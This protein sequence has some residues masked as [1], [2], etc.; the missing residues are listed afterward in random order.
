VQIAVDA[1]DRLDVVVNAARSADPAVEDSSVES[2][3]VP[4]ETNLFGFAYLIDATLPILRQQRSGHIIGISP[5]GSP[6]LSLGFSGY[7]IS[8][9]A[10]EDFTLD[11]AQKV[12]PFGIK[13]TIVETGCTRN[14]P[15]ESSVQAVSGRYRWGVVGTEQR[16]QA[17]E[18][19][20]AN[21]PGSVAGLLW[22]VG[23]AGPPLRLLAGSD[24]ARLASDAGQR[25]AA[26]EMK[27]RN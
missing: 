16:V 18:S 4:I 7:H 15:L 22:V 20:E 17:H 27:W 3:R 1:R 24:C 25:L 9:D 5:E 12:A 23:I 21:D 2:F 14:T 10:I 19:P 26:L 8:K 13:V 11:L 6:I